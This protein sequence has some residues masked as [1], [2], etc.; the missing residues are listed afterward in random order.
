MTGRPVQGDHYVLLN[1]NLRREFGERLADLDWDIALLQEVPV[2]WLGELARKTGA[3]GRF[4]LT[5]RNWMSPV[6]APIWSRRPHLVGSWEGGS[7]LILVRRGRNVRPGRTGA[8]TLR[9]RPE[10]RRL[11]FVGLEDGPIVFNLHASTGSS[12][13]SEDVMRAAAIAGGEASGRPIVFGGD[14][15]VRPRSA[16]GL[17][18]LLAG[19]HDLKLPD[20]ADPGSIDQVLGSGAD[21]GTVEVLRPEL[22]EFRDDETGLVA[23]LS[24]HDPVMARLDF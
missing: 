19:D 21:P 16:P 23:R 2:S 17:F 11:Q 20:G 15:N 9:L 10:R 18:E 4:A 8:F 14:L 1:R 13:A 6:T 5:S 3:I 12:R 7:N 22:R 24:D